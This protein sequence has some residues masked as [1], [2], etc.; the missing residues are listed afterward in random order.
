MSTP[1]YCEIPCAEAALASGPIVLSEAVDRFEREA[2]KGTLDTGRYRLRYF[3]WGSGPPLVIVH[4]VGDSSRS[5]IPLASRLSSRFRCVAYDLP[6]QHGDGAS[7]W[8]YRHEQLVEDLFAL[9]DHLSLPRA[10]MLGASLGGSVVLRALRHSPQR[11]PRAIIQGGFAHRPLKWSEW[12]LTWFARFLP[13]TMARA[14]Y[15][16]KVLTA[17]HKPPFE[18]R[19]E[20]WWQAFLDWTGATPIATLGQQG[21]LLHSLDLRPDLPHVCQP[22]LLMVGERDGTMGMPHTEALRQGLPNCGVVVLEGAGHVPC[23]SHP[24]MMA[25]VIRQFLTPPSE[26]ACPMADICH[27]KGEGVTPGAPDTR[28]ELPCLPSPRHG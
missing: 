13:G 7:L 10:Y 6:G 28:Q 2:K 20:S 26:A 16:Q 12:W 1:N 14:P 22:V 25:E 23:Y 17:I 15:R 21:Q 4:G 27:G 11:V 8:W 24:E 19:D 18:G 3:V 5:F 9:L